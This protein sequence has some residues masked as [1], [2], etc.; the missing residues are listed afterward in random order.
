MDPLREGFWHHL[1][2]DCSGDPDDAHLE[3]IGLT[4][5][6]GRKDEVAAGIVVAVRGKD[7]VVEAA[8]DLPELLRTVGELPVGGH[9]IEPQSV[10]NR[11][12]RLPLRLHGGVGP[13]DGVAAVEREHPPRPRIPHRVK[14]CGYPGIAPG[15]QVFGPI[16]GPEELGVQFQVTVRVVHLQERNL[17]RH[18]PVMGVGDVKT[19]CVAP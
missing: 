9:G 13:V 2:D 5:G 4:D 19:L 7:R 10:E 6:V 14:E 11:D 18:G 15:H 3:P 16:S 1:V 17:I 12:E 8:G